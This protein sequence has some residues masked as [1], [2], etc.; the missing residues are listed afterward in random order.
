MPFARGMSL[1]TPIAATAVICMTTLSIGAAADQSPQKNPEPRVPRSAPATV[2]ATP[3]NGKVRL[4][5]TPVSGAVGYHVYRGING[6]WEPQ[7]VAKTNATAQTV[8]NLEN[9]TRYSFT[10]AGYTAD[11]DGP[12]S[13]A[14]LVTPL[15]PPGNVTAIAGDR[16]VTLKWEKSAGATSYAIYRRMTTDVEFTEVAIGVLASPFIDTGLTNGQRYYYSIRAVAGDA[17]SD[18]ST[19]ASAVAVENGP[20]AY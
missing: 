12:L 6:R 14:V 10:V 5:W 9:G 7:P 1:F 17:Q 15:A 3:G 2:V 18:L 16:R 19:R 8:V 4:S 11:G 20:G 13:L